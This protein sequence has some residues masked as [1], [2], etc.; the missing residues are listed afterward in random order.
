MKTTAIVKILGVIFAFA[1]TVSSAQAGWLTITNRTDAPLVIQEVGRGQSASS[2]G[3]TIRLLPGEVYREYQSTAGTK[4]VAI[5]PIGHPERSE[6]DGRL[7]WGSAD[8]SYDLRATGETVSLSPSD[9]SYSAQSATV[10]SLALP[11]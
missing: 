6:L 9:D 3:R 7:A 1:S 8:T 5:Y 4:S 11:R 10:M 2:A